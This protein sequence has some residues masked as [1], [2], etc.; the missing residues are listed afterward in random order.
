MK[1]EKSELEKL[2]M[3]DLLEICS[4]SKEFGYNSTRFLQMLAENGPINTCR[5]LINTKDISYAS[6][7]V[8]LWE[9]HRLD[10]SMEY[11]VL[12]NKYRKLFTLPERQI[13]LG[14]LKECGFNCDNISVE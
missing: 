14:R 6:G 9:V 5:K 8:R 3:A 11:V 10:L 13:C 4:K 7:F 12:Q 1:N 2:L